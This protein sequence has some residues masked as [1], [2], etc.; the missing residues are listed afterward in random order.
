MLRN[1]EDNGQHMWKGLSKINCLKEQYYIDLEEE[2]MLE[3]AEKRGGMS[4]DTSKK[5][6]RSK[7]Q[8][9]RR[10]RRNTWP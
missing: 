9:Y 10:R 2:K 1:T 6:Q 4:G 3:D 8:L 5:V 7:T